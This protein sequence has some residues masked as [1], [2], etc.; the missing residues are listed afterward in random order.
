MDDGDRYSIPFQCQEFGTVLI[1]GNPKTKD[2]FCTAG[3]LC[4]DGENPGEM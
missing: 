4:S 1:K 2:P 3:G